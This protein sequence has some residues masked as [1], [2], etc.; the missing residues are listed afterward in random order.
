MKRAVFVGVGL[1]LAA[2]F[3]A[4]ARAQINGQGPSSNGSLGA[5]F[6]TK[7]GGFWGRVLDQKGK[8]Y[9]GAVVK[10]SFA[11]MG[12]SQVMIGNTQ[13]IRRHNTTSA[14]VNETWRLKTDQHGKYKIY[15][16]PTGMFRVSLYSPQG[17]L[18]YRYQQVPDVSL[19]FPINHIDF[20]LKKLLSPAAELAQMTPAERRRYAAQVAALKKQERRHEHIHHLNQI[21]RREAQLAAGGH[22]HMAQSLMQSAVALDAKQPLLWARLGDAEM[23]LNQPSQAIQDY[24]QALA[25]EPN[26]SAVMINLANALAGTGQFAAAGRYLRQARVLDP[27]DAKIVFYNEGVMLFNRRQYGAAATDF[28][29]AVQ[30]D[31]HYARAWF[32]R[33]MSLLNQAVAATGKGKLQILPGTIEAFK[34]FLVLDPDGAHAQKA[35]AMLSAIQA[36]QTPEIGTMH[37]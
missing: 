19:S 8:P 10:I 2:M 12:Q 32:G 20:N 18:L 30:L 33:G 1:G 28:N 35:R 22:W 16:L 23:N 13:Q 5:N 6:N 29:R 34:R 36:Q 11:A 14:S 4:P 21:L 17:R 26:Q 15:G 7:L 3:S 27:M 37:P 24:R 31:S 9:P 25:L